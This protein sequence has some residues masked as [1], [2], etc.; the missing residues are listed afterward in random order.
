METPP[1][2]RQQL[3]AYL[4]T[5]VD[6]GYSKRTQEAYRERLR[7]FVDWCELRDVRHAPQ[8]SLALLESWQ[9][10]LRS[11]RKADGQYYTSGGLIN[12]LSALRGWFRWLLKRHHILYN[13][14]E[15][16]TMP[17]E[18]KRLPAQV[19]SET[20]TETVLMSIDIQ[21]PLGLR[22]RALLEVFW[23]TGIRR[24]ELI[25]LKLSD[26]DSGRGVIMVRQGKG[27]KDRVVPIG[28]R[29][30]AW[31]NRYLADVRPRLA[32]K[33]D[34]GYLFITL[35][36]QPLARSTVTLMAGRTIRQQARLNKPGTCHV[37]RHSMATQMLENGAD[38]RHIQAIL[39]HEK[40]ETT[41]IYTRV[42]IGHLKAV[43]H[44]TH[45]AERDSRA[46]SDTEPP[47][48]G[49]G[50]SVAESPAPDNPQRRG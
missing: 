47:E 38:T 13:P 31:V 19:L 41:Q 14:A 28:E 27:R 48:S 40:L 6:R 29:A 20:E 16:L 21:T 42:A 43:H 10:Y 9:R 35:K 49:S 22:N 32:W 25:N 8:V 36:G 7:P 4:D 3:E 5:V 50:H 15:L 18:E 12:R 2:L 26:I 33:Y 46:D 11:Y 30:L 1:T 34:S 17:K 44:Q 24:N 39:G 37:F 23:S 45:P